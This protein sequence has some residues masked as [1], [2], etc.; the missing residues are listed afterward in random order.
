MTL[1]FF[2]AHQSRKEQKDLNQPLK[3]TVY[4]STTLANDFL[5]PDFIIKPVFT[6]AFLFEF[7]DNKQSLIAWFTAYIYPYN[8]VPEDRKKTFRVSWD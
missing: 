7:D 6:Q 8:F 5:A 1:Q 2:L 4:D 3:S